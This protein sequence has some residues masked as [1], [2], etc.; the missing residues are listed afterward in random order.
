MKVPFSPCII[1]FQNK[2]S[3]M[4]YWGYHGSR[5]LLDQTSMSWFLEGDQKRHQWDDYSIFPTV[6]QLQRTI[7]FWIKGG[8]VAQQ[9]FPWQWSAMYDMG[10]RARSVEGITDSQVNCVKWALFLLG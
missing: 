9:L 6:L 7:H 3:A 1:Q 10:R 2:A 4:K 8:D 5:S